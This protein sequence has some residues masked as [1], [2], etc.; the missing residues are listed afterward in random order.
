MR[1]RRRRALPGAQAGASGC[2]LRLAGDDHLLLGEQL[3]GELRGAGR[4]RGSSTRHRD[5]R[6]NRRLGARHHQLRPRREPV[7]ASTR[8]CGPPGGGNAARSRAACRC[9]LRALLTAASHAGHGAN[10]GVPSARRDAC[11]A[12]PCGRW[13]RTRDASARTARRRMAWP[14]RAACRRSSTALWRKARQ[15]GRRGVVR[16]RRRHSRAR[17][18]GSAGGTA[19]HLPAASQAA[20]AAPRTPR[21]GG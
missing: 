13:Q 7:G 11:A 14:A 19:R 15:R 10:G 2:A 12:P 1:R 9:A 18:R 5:R 4:R 6:P 21:R 20:D 16:Q 3:G 8:Q 17:P